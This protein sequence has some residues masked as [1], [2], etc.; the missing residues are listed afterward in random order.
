MLINDAKKANKTDINEDEIH[1]DEKGSKTI[2]FWQLR[3]QF[4]IKINCIPNDGFNIINSYVFL[5]NKINIE[6]M[7]DTNDDSLVEEKTR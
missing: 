1:D 7:N 6:I 4:D 2:I 3:T 5:S